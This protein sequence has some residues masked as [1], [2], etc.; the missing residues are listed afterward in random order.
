MTLARDLVNDIREIKTRLRSLESQGFTP[1]GEISG[2]SAYY[3]ADGSLHTPGDVFVG[4]S[5]LHVG[6]ELTNS[7]EDSQANYIQWDPGN[8]RHQ[9]ISEEQGNWASVYILANIQGLNDVDVWAIGQAS[10]ANGG[11]LHFTFVN[12]TADGYNSTADGTPIMNLLQSGSVGIGTDVGEA[13]V[14]TF[15]V[16]GSTQLSNSIGQANSHIPYTDGEIYLTGDLDGTGTGDINI[17]TW[18]A[19]GS[20]QQYAIFK[21]DTQRFGVGTTSPAALVEF[22]NGSQ[23]TRFSGND[24]QFT[25]NSAS[26]LMSVTAG[27]YLVFHTNGTTPGLGNAAM[28]LLTSQDMVIPNGGLHIGSTASTAYALEVRGANSYFYERMGIGDTPESTGRLILGAGTGGRTLVFDGGDAMITVHDGS[29]NFNI[30]SG[31]DESNNA[32]ANTGGS[33]LRM[34]DQGPMYLISYSGGTVG[35][36][37]TTPTQLFI[38]S[39]AFEFSYPGNTYLRI[40]PKSTG[41]DAI[42]EFYENSVLRA[43]IF[44]DGGVDDFKIDTNLGD[45]LL[46]PNSYVGINN[47]GPQFMLDV[48]DNNPANG[49]VVRVLS[50]GNASGSGGIA[51]RAGQD[52]NPTHNAILFQDG[53][54]TTIGRINGNGSG[55][56]NYNSSSDERRKENQRPLDPAPIWAGLDNLRA[57]S[58]TGRG[59][60]RRVAGALAQDF[61]TLL[62]GVTAEDE[63][64]FLS[65]DY[66]RAGL[67]LS[68]VGLKQ[69]KAKIEA[70]EARIA[71]LEQA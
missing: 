5:I 14:H 3:R 35:N 62:P 12:A 63:N 24:I 25:R 42:L 20:Y 32:V 54:G 58:Y 31:M 9:L 10:E 11:G 70:L 71:V 68:I 69:A 51:I 56:V 55:G 6:T 28:A 43:T 2:S 16:K 33:H 17:R 48:W 59:G 38:N 49:Y 22:D 18:D 36:P 34:D 67:T 41:T 46:T 45:I 21:G 60:S 40:N 52:T 61:V 64:G 15:H 4:G 50:D 29:G 26:Y 23:A 13:L 1:A 8:S 57:I 53:N 44:Y 19:V 47:T 7:L 37:V 66:G 30:K 27:G 65:M 39:A